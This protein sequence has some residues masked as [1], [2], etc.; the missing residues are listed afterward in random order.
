MRNRRAFSLV[1]LLVV[2]A[3]IGLLT[4]LV[5][6][7]IGNLASTYRL[8]Q[9]TEDV[10][11]QLALARQR[12]ITMNRTVEARFY[13]VPGTNGEP[14]GYKRMLLVEPSEGAGN[15]RAFQNPLTLPP[16]VFVAE[17]SDWS[18][19]IG[20]PSPGVPA[21]TLPPFTDNRRWFSIRF[22]PDGSSSVDASRN[23]FTL[24]LA[25]SADDL[26]KKDASNIATLQIAPQTGAIQ[27]YRP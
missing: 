4:A 2:I 25:R 8:S 9:A 17:S 20:T 12:A 24:I 15:G 1:E 13:Q 26:S 22:Y 3:V 16:T 27:I 7:A 5:M 18:P 19:V 6:P 11:G 14:Q 21:G 10:A 23:F